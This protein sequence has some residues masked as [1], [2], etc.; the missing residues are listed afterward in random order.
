MAPLVFGG[1][2]SQRASYFVFIFAAIIN[3]SRVAG[4]L[5]NN[6][7]HV[8]SVWWNA[9]LSYDIHEVSEFGDTQGIW[10]QELRTVLSSTLR[11]IEAVE[12]SLVR[13]D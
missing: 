10:D 3:C 1:S 4:D 6:G 5:R 13:S 8:K 2:L 7:A 11:K 9:G 12:E